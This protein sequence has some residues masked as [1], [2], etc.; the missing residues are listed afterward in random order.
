[1]TDTDLPFR[2]PARLRAFVRARE[3]SIIVLAAAVG[4]LGGLGVVVM[5]IAVNFMHSRFFGLPSGERE[6]IYWRNL[7]ALSPR[8]IALAAR[9]EVVAHG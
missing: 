5:D 2:A 4:V 7:V 6:Q 9:E 3:F 1:M 8:L